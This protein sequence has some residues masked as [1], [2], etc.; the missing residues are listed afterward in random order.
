MEMDHAS[1][2]LGQHN[3]ME[4]RVLIYL[5]T[6]EQDIWW[7]DKS[8]LTTSIVSGFIVLNLSDEIKLLNSYQRHMDQHETYRGN[9]RPHLLTLG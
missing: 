1:I 2:E 9:P 3:H 7:A 4:G 8:I 5:V 6:K